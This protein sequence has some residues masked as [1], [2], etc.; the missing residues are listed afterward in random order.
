M[1]IKNK[2]VVIT[3]SSSGIGRAIALE[4]AKAGARIVLNYQT[5]KEGGQSTLREIKSI[6]AEAM[7]VQADISKLEDVKRLFETVIKRFGTVDILINN[8]G[9]K[10]VA[11]P[12]WALDQGNIT[13]MIMTNLVGPMFCSHQAITIMQKQGYG[14]ILNTSSMR[15]AEYAGKAIIYASTKAALNSFTR[16]LAK[17][18]SPQIQVNAVAPGYVKTRSFD[19]ASEQVI[20]ELS[21]QTPIKRFVT[22]EEVAQAF[23]FL[24]QN[25]AITGQVLYVDGGFTLK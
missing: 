13:G 10:H 5:N 11:D 8:A 19:N 23:L 2:V 21:E 14:K 4:F 9:Y 16:T 20:I 17:Q 7:I 15:G 18:V 22:E 25:D 1:D 12:F 3:G 24:A 6:G